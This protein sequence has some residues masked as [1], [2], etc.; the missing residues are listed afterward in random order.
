MLLLRSKKEAMKPYDIEI[1]SLYPIDIL[2][3]G[4]TILDILRYKTT[5]MIKQHL[6]TKPG[7]KGCGGNITFKGYHPPHEIV[8]K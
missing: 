7:K 3:V 2:L 1:R 8:S 5:K 6:K 4:S